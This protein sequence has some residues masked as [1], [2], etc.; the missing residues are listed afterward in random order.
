MVNCQKKKKFWSLQDDAVPTKHC[1]KL[2]EGRLKKLCEGRFMKLCEGRFMK[3]CEGRLM[4][5]IV[6]LLNES[7]IRKVRY[8]F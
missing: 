8:F 6:S 7:A 2:C 1:F 5:L 4:K 3:L